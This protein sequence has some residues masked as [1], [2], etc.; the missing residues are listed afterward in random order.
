[1]VFLAGVMF[2]WPFKLSIRGKVVDVLKSALAPDVK[3]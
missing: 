3:G 2:A 1:V